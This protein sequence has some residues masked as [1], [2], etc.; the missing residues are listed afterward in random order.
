MSVSI[1]LQQV[2]STYNDEDNQPVYKS[3]NEV[4]GT[5][6]IP[7]ALFVFAVSDDSF[8]HVASTHDLEAYPASAVEAVND[9]VDFY[10]LSQ[11]TREFD[12]IADAQAFALHVRS[13]LQFLSND[14]P[15]TKDAFVGTAVY[16]YV[17]SG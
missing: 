9:G 7:L 3:A 1:T 4:T 11:V 10:R 12:N 6:G 15:A 13:R 17:T 5:E 16:T 2:N 8:S 14:Y